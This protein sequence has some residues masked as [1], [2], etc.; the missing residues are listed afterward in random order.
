MAA[1]KGANLE[2]LVREY[3]AR[4]GLFA[5]RSVPLRYEDEEVTDIDVWCYGRQSASIRTRTLVDVKSKRSPKAFER[6]LWSRGMQ[7]ALNCDKAIVATTDR[8][9]KIVRFAR[10]QEVAL[11]TKGFLDRLRRKIDTSERQT[12]EQFL[13]NIRKY[14]EHKQDGDWIKLIADAKSAVISL[15][16]YPA[17]NKSMTM[18][19]FFADRAHTRPQHKEQAVRA[20]Y[21]VAA[22]ACIALDDALVHVVYEDT[23]TRYKAITE[24]VRYGDA[25]DGKV[26]K[27]I[28]KVLS[29]MG[30]GMENGR[31]VARQAKDAMDTLFDRVRSEIIA[32]Y[33]AK[34]NNAAKLF[35]V[36]KELDS[37][38]HSVNES[39]IM[40][41]SIEAKS[42]LGV[43]SDFVQTN[44][45][46]LLNGDQMEISD[47]LS[48]NSKSGALKSESGEGNSEKVAKRES[49]GDQL[50]LL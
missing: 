42:V 36:A 21:L 40:D 32:E 12:L 14:P 29:V 15:H 38:A 1:R 35:A 8:N 23:P 25:G 13:E 44:R 7:L 27:S 45:A 28:D 22:L 34:E 16:G 18:F 9:P 46:V 4:Q 3:L 24:G 37:R 49:N 26:Q 5:L 39:K 6:I 17:F 48:T 41:L 31:V 50:K 11:L 19:R 43:F 2:E 10:Q 20:S 30:Q 33:F 47:A